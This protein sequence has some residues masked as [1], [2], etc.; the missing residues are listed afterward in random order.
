MT[1]PGP[2]RGRRRR[3]TARSSDLRGRVEAMREAERVGGVGA[4]AGALLRLLRDVILLVRDLV[5]D[6]RVPQ[7]AKWTPA[8]LAL[9]YIASPIDLV[10]DVIPVLGRLDDL[11]VLTWAFRRLLRDAG[12]EVTYELWRGTDEGLAIVLELAGAHE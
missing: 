5:T 9:A 7:R 4:T 12:Y 3:F 2:P 8:G 1:V 11:L 10:P 6:P